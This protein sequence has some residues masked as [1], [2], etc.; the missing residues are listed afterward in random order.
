MQRPEAIRS[1]PAPDPAR[2]VTNAAASPPGRPEPVPLARIAAVRQFNRFYTRRLGVLDRQLLASGFS[3][4][5]SRVLWELAHGA[6][7]TASWLREELGLD[8]GYLSRLLS[9]LRAAGLIR[10]RTDREDA[11]AQS[12]S[13]TAAGR[14]AFDRLDRASQKQI[15]QWLADLN[16]SSQGQLVQALDIVTALLGPAPRAGEITLHEPR[17]G[18]IGWVIQRHGA[19]YAEEYGWDLSFEA[20]VARIAADFVDQRQ[21]DCERG[22]IARRDGVNVGCVFVVRAPPADHGEAVAKLRLLLVEPSMRG[23][24]L[25]DRLV[26]ECE[27]FALEAG[28]RR[29]TLWTNSILHAARAIYQRRG[30]TLVAE[31]SHHSFGQPLTG[32]TWE[33]A[34]IGNT[35]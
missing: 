18:D 25:G 7:L 13:L 23:A 24:G 33:K 4:T 8:A 16:P 29:M 6:P 9:R 31:E 5:E 1:A 30:W 2:P 10:A 21:P 15:G 17:P 22:W 34:L 3:L 11:R 28:Y 12:L 14:R 32:Q 27:R 19:L 26:A 20:L 35:G